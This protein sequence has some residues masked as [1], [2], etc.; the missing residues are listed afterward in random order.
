MRILW[1]I[2]L[3][4]GIHFG[5]WCLPSGYAQEEQDLFREIENIKDPFM[6][7][8][9]PPKATPQPQTV[10]NPS[11]IVQ[12][13]EA[14]PPPVVDTGTGAPSQFIPKVPNN[15]LKE[16]DSG[17]MIIKGLVWNTDIPQAI[18]NDKVVR[19]GDEVGGMKIIS[20]RQ[21]GVELSNDDLSVFLRIS[22]EKSAAGK[23]P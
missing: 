21:K 15:T 18:V 23:K 8:L 19:V 6:P 11:A 9:P 22:A 1:A 7:Q 5:G 17:A 4:M 2:I 3:S 16:Q 14:P 10:M 20:I 12:H 13:V